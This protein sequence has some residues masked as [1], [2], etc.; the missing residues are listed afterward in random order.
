MQLFWL[1]VGSVVEHILNMQKAADLVSS[2]PRP[3]LR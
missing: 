3:Q 2:H 1:E